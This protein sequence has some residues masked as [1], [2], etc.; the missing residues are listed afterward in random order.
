MTSSETHEIPMGL[1][2][3]GNSQPV[4]L[5]RLNFSSKDDDECRWLRVVTIRL[6]EKQYYHIPIK[7][8]NLIR[9]LT[10]NKVKPFQPDHWTK[11]LSK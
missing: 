9:N 3:C 6:Y 4:R 8:S 10:T 5:F 1:E 2:L 7:T 11:L